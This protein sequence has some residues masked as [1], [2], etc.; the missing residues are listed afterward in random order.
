MSCLLSLR[1][2][3]GCNKAKLK[4]AIAT[5]TGTAPEAPSAARLRRELQ[6]L[7]L[8]ESLASYTLALLF[9]TSERGE[10]AVVAA[11]RLRVF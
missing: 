7:V 10:G 1:S 6:P 3:H 9:I 11:R 4:S 5:A 8:A 2:Q